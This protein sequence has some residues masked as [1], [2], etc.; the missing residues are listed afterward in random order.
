MN[1]CRACNNDLGSVTA[2]DAHR[3]GRHAYSFSEGLRMDPL[4]EDGRRCLDEDEMEARGFVKNGRGG[5]W[6]LVS[7]GV[8]ACPRMPIPARESASNARRGVQKVR[9]VS[10]TCPGV[11]RLEADP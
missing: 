2:F 6:P 4:R 8:G 10:G 1:L 9:T 11:S 7:S 5:V 3:T